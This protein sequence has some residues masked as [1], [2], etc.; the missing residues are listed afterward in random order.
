M[1]GAGAVQVRGSTG[2]PCPATM[3]RGTGTG[4][5]E[6]IKFLFFLPKEERRGGQLEEQRCELLCQ[7]SRGTQGKAGRALRTQDKCSD[8][9]VGFGPG[10]GRGMRGVRPN[11]GA[12][13]RK[14]RHC[15]REG[16]RMLGSGRTREALPIQAAPTHFPPLQSQLFSR[17]WRRDSSSREAGGGKG[18]FF[19]LWPSEPSPP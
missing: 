18:V 8:T 15:G 12:G 3:G 11:C 13:E 10:P 14:Q 16:G 4:W 9:S 5:L 17:G 1:Q 2:T 19:S 7:S 6:N